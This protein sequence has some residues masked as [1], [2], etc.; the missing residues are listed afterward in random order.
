MRRCRLEGS[1]WQTQCVWNQQIVIDATAFDELE[2][3]CGTAETI[4]VGADLMQR[5]I[6]PVEKNLQHD[7]VGARGNGAVALF[8]ETDSR[9]EAVP[10]VP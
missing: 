3:L 9:R 1:N 8:R 2:P 10:E 5:R 4:V 6:G 7:V